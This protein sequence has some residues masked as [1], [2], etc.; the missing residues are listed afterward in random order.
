MLPASQRFE[1]GAQIAEGG[2]VRCRATSPKDTRSSGER[3]YLRHVRI[4]LGSL[5]ELDTQL[6]L[7]V[8]LD[9]LSDSG[10]ASRS[11]T[12]CNA[13]GQLLHGLRTSA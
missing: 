12:A 1:L 5:A 10:C 11:A 9:L 8:R 7:A 3:T 13:S 2:D 4:A 6:E